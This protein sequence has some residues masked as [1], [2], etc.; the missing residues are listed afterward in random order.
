MAKFRFRLQPVLRQREIAERDEQLKVAQVER[1]RLMLE[2]RLRQCQQRIF[3][4]PW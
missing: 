1:Q 3:C 2:D 4:P